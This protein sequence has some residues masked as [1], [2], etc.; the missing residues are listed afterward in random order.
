MIVM[1]VGIVF[2]VAG[3][4]TYVLVANE[5]AA[6]NITVS[7]DA[8]Y[9]AGQAVNSPWT[10]YSEAETIS[11]HALE[12][13]GGKT[14]AELERDDPLRDTAMQASFLRA[15]LF[16]SVVAFGVAALAAVLGVVLF[17][18]GMSLRGLGTGVV[19]PRPPTPAT[20]PRGVPTATAVGVTRIAEPLG[21]TGADS[22][23]GRSRLRT[24][25]PPRGIR[26]AVARHRG[27][28]LDV[29]RHQVVAE[30]ALAVGLPALALRGRGG[31]AGARVGPARAGRCPVP[32]FAG[33]CCWASSSGVASCSRPPGC[34]T[35]SAGLSGF[36]TGSSVVMVPVVASVVF[37][38]RVRPQGWLAVGLS[39]AGLV[40]LTAG[41][42]GTLT[43]GAL[44]TLAGAA[45][46]A[47]HIT[48]LSS[49]ATPSNAVGITTV[50]VVVAAVLCGSWSALAGQLAVPSSRAAWASVLWVAVVA[51]CLGLAVQAWAQGALS[52]TS[53]A[54]IMTME[55]VFA[56]MLAVVVAGEVLAPSA[57]LG[58]V[59]VVVAM[60]TAE[61]GARECCDVAA[62]RVECC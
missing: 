3:V 16:T 19:R 25:R 18:I 33:A 32:T 54:V 44:L 49:W 46:F 30:R 15:S 62:P 43:A 24:P 13:T 50:S 59:L 42:G 11:K 27:L 36:L 52:A 34:S 4:A 12:A 45:G 22:G 39:A 6:E 40:L 61:I 17:L 28:G 7:A 58:G 56:A 41:P 26:C 47:G 9:F 48:A 14:Y 5:L 53:A 20:E 1:V 55:P 37:S 2:A 8:E 51:T 29:R 21:R 35:T 23:C 60:G 10:A 57:W 31:G 38:T